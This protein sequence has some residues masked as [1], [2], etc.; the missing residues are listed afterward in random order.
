MNSFDKIEIDLARLYDICITDENDRKKRNLVSFGYLKLYFFGLLRKAGIW[1]RLLYSG[2]V[3]NWFKEFEI[4][5]RTK[6]EG[7][8]IDVIDFHYLRLHY[9]RK[10]Q[11]V[12]HQD[13][14]NEAKY[15]DAWQSDENLYLLLGSIWRYAKKAYLDFYT[16]LKYLPSKGRILEYGAGIAPITTGL[17]KYLPHRKYD[18]VIADIMQIN[19]VYA[20]DKLKNNPS[21]EYKLLTPKENVIND[22]EKYD[23]IFCETVLEHTP[24]S[25]EIVE[26]F[27]NSL[28]YGGLLVFDYILADGDGLDSKR[29]AAVRNRVIE[30][31][32]DNFVLVKGVLD[33]KNTMG[34]TIVRKVKY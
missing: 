13:E 30:Y 18:Y 34:N 1:E 28:K 19:F 6:L 17:L 31:I 7:R 5:W 8:P 27:Y 26:G 22:V 23:V 16:N 3:L 15:L 20:I 21:V 10:F 33:K 12:A 2:L 14:S 24:N 32:D 4:F 29:S 25:D 11:S 9:R